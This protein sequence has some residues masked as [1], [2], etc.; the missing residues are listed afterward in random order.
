MIEGCYITISTDECALEEG[1]VG[2]CSPNT[3]TMGYQ[4]KYKLC[5]MNLR[6]LLLVI[7]ASVVSMDTY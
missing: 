5:N 3:D 6:A 1:V 2:H 4:S 7:M